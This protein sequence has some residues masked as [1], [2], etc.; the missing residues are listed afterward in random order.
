MSRSKSRPRRNQSKSSAK[1]ISQDPQSWKTEGA[2]VRDS[3]DSGPRHRRY[4]R[5]M[6]YIIIFA[7]L[8]FL[9]LEN[10]QFVHAFINPGGPRWLSTA[11]LLVGVVSTWLFA[12]ALLVAQIRA[13]SLGEKFRDDKTVDNLITVALSRIG[14]FSLWATLVGLLSLSWGPVPDELTVINTLGAYVTLGAL[15]GFALCGYESVL[16]YRS[17]LQLMRASGGMA[18]ARYLVYAKAADSFCTIP[19][20]LAVIHLFHTPWVTRLSFILFFYISS[21]LIVHRRGPGQGGSPAPD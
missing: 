15:I 14:L 4:R 12:R 17:S 8:S 2:N 11:T 20:I 13:V 1:A 18:D 10:Q 9:L 7:M 21:R 19:V 5:P 3:P 16:T 6:P